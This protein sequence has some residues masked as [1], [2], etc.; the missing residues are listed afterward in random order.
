M[1]LSLLKKNLESLLSKKN[2]SRDDIELIFVR[3]RLILE[4]LNIKEE[5]SQLNFYCDWI[6]HPEINR[7]N[8]V[9]DLILN[10][11]EKI[12]KDF[13][14]KKP[15][16]IPSL[17]DPNKLSNELNI[18]FKEI[19]K[20]NNYRINEQNWPSFFYL[21]C[22][23]LINRP[24]KIPDNPPKSYQ[25]KIEQIK[26]YSTSSGINKIGIISFEL[27]IA[28]EKSHEPIGTILWKARAIYKNTIF[29]GRF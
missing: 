2:I 25:D 21:I 16:D 22:E 5:Y 26:N 1:S 20:S 10:L 4:K 23:I 15:I 11:N 29:M 9:I 13:D 12:L 28:D 7:P 18:F 19:L 27:E 17:I 8:K 6:V 24:L 3:I 14:L